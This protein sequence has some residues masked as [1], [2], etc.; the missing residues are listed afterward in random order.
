MDGQLK[1]Y[2]G[3]GLGMNFLSFTWGYST[4]SYTVFGVTYGGSNLAS[5]SATRI[6]INL[7]GG[8]N[9]AVGNITIFPEVRYVLASD[10]NHFMFKVGATFPL[11]K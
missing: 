8:A 3:A 2:V 6:G 5:E 9:Y 4:P 11:G 1:P 7:I 10:F